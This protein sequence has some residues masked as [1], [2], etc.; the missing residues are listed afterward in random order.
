[1]TSPGW[2]R[3][4][5]LVVVLTALAMAA[6]LVGPSEAAP[7]RWSKVAVS[8]DGHHWHRNLTRPLFDSAMVWVPGDTV[9]RSFY[10]KNRGG[11]RARLSVLLTVDDQRSL[12]RAGDLRFFVRSGARW[13]RVSRPRGQWLFRVKLRPGGVKRVW[14]RV[15]LHPRAGNSTMR[16][17]EP[18]NLRVRLK[19]TRH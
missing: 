16:Q 18:F 1:M 9:T 10:V 2:R 6:V 4:R 19:S 12:M 17:R 14:V 7:R 8:R 3:C 5:G 13:V 15:Q 11:R